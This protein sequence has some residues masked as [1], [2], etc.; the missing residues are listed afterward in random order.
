M[1]IVEATRAYEAW[2]A[3]QLGSLFVR[4]DLQRKHT[5]MAKGPFP[6]LRATYYRWAEQILDICPELAG[7]PPVIAVGDI[8]LENFGTWRDNDGRLIWGV[9]DFDEAAEMPYALDLVRLGVSAMLGCPHLRSTR[10]ISN[11]ILRGYLQGLAKPGPIVLDHQHTWLRDLVVVPDAARTRFWMK[12]YNTANGKK[13]AKEYVRALV[14]SMPEGG[15]DLTYG[16]RTAGLG[17][18]G[19]PR[20]I[21]V[22]EWRGGP[23]VREA[24][25]ALPSAWTLPSG[26]RK[27]PMYCD[28]IATAR[29]RAPDP[30][31]RL[32][33]DIMVRRLSPNN[34][35]LDVTEYPLALLNNK[36]L[37]LMGCELAA[38]HFGLD[39]RRAAVMRDLERRDSAWLHFAIERAVQFV[40]DEHR[41]WRYSRR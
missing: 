20:W 30:W 1:G 6:F 33:G 12:M 3:R 27:Q 37:R 38:V 22:A 35:K 32:V 19:R 21:G 14:G 17:S 28:K 7:A 4:K 31:Y 15:L 16:A 34:R 5:R 11:N 24:K 13:P 2:L 9:N 41:E 40:R 23:V 18:L 25:A 10:A 26:R 29:Y 8:H 36:M 39:D